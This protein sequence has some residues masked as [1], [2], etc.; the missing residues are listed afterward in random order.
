F[1]IYALKDEGAGRYLS[2]E[3]LFAFY[4]STVTSQSQKSDIML[5]AFIAKDTAKP[6]PSKLPSPKPPAED[7]EADRLLR[8]QT[9]L[10][11]SQLD[12]LANLELNFVSDPIGNFDST[13]VVLMNEAYQPLA[14][15]SFKRDTADKKITIVYPWVANTSYNL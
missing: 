3:Q 1:A 10:S 15:Y 14:G 9:N 8:L 11:N 7:E 4:D 6:Q 13:K 12:L 2:R 5:Y